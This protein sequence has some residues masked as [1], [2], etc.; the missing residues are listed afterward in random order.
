MWTICQQTLFWKEAGYVLLQ[1]LTEDPFMCKTD[2][3]G[4]ASLWEVHC[5]SCQIWW[6]GSENI[7]QHQHCVDG[8]HQLSQVKVILV[9]INTWGWNTEETQPQQLQSTSREL[10]ATE[11]YV[12]SCDLF[13]FFCFFLWVYHRPVIPLIKA[14]LLWLSCNWQ[15]RRKKLIIQTSPC[16]TLKA[17]LK[18]SFV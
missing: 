17:K 7:L 13:F 5:Q 18:Q 8:K 2:P 14:F 4:S 15:L 6:V 10:L 16:W 11:V 9:K 1:N 3:I 12:L